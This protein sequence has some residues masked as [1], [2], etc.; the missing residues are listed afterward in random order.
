[1]KLVIS[2]TFRV[3]SNLSEESLK[4]RVEKD[5]EEEAPEVPEKKS[6]VEEKSEVEEVV[7]PEEATA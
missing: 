2:Y 1:M 4:R 6:K 5:A 3:I 7:E